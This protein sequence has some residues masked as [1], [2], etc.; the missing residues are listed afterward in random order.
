MVYDPFISE[1][2]FGEDQRDFENMKE[3][4]PE[5]V[6]YLQE[7]VEQECGRFEYAGSFIYDQYPDR[8]TLDRMCERIMEAAQAS[9]AVEAMAWGRS[10]MPPRRPGQ[11]DRPSY[12]PKRPPMPHSD[13]LKDLVQVLLYN[14]IYRRRCNGRKC[15][16]VWNF[17]L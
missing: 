9:P 5:T 12:P 16:R 17:G 10:S 2:D 13:P 11:P 4:Y 6:R 3:M 7:L 8:I 14:E 15:R 1:V